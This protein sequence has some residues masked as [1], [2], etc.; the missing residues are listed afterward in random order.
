MMLNLLRLPAWL[1]ITLHLQTDLIN[2]SPGPQVI[3]LLLSWNDYG[4]GHYLG[5][6]RSTAGIP[7]VSSFNRELLPLGLY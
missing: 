6:M 3:E 5:P 4:E 2:L 7:F 1:N